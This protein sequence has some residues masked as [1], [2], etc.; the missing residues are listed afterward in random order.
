[1]I[2]SDVTNSELGGWLYAAA[3]VAQ[4][5]A[6]I[7]VLITVNSKQ[8]REVTFAGEPV[9]KREFDRH[10][11]ENAAV[12]HELFAKIGGAE[13]GLEDRLTRRLDKLEQQLHEGREKMHDRINDV[14]KSIGQ[15]NSS[16][17]N[18]EA[19]IHQQ[20]Q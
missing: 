17:S 7:T 3:T 13:R 19:K 16:I 15:I 4:L 14:I 11:A 10:L 6:T 12:H 5:A 18:L 20:S 9:D 1:M 2:L 8:R